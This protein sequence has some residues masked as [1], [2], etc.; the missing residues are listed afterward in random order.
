MA[1]RAKPEARDLTLGEELNWPGLIFAFWDKSGDPQ[2]PGLNKARENGWLGADGAVTAAG[3]DELRRLERENDLMR[4]SRQAEQPVRPAAALHETRDGGQ[5]PD[6][7]LA[8]GGEAAAKPQWQL[9]LEAARR[10]GGGLDEARAG[11]TALR[12]EKEKKK[13]VK[14]WEEFHNRVWNVF[15]RHLE[16]VGR[17][18]EAEYFDLQ[19]GVTAHNWSI[20]LV[21]KNGGNGNGEKKENGRGSRDRVNKTFKNKP[22]SDI[23]ISAAKSRDAFRQ[24]MNELEQKFS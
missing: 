23:V 8:A 2:N 1:E 22:T 11:A 12:K 5:A 21:R 6:E 3:K 4:V 18:A 19:V 7:T 24:F 16:K 14:K 15:L 9:I 20:Y 13:E 10:P 17:T